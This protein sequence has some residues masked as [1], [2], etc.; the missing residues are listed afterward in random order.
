[1][2]KAVVQIVRLVIIQTVPIHRVL[3]VVLVHTVIK[4]FKLPLLLA[5]HAHRA[6][7]PPLKLSQA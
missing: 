5:K 4:F 1:M 6:R 7:I 3:L 2:V